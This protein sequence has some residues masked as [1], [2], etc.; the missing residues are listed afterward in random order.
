MRL[1]T[2][3]DPLQIERDWNWRFLYP[4][5]PSVRPPPPVAAAG[6]SRA[7][8]DS[9]TRAETPPH[10]QVIGQDGKAAPVS[11]S[12]EQ[13]VNMCLQRSFGN[14]RQMWVSDKVSE[15]LQC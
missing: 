11:N 9:R 2:A 14:G 15:A 8:F 5:R 12:G 4:L 3:V 13:V 6:A 1:S 7:P 10:R